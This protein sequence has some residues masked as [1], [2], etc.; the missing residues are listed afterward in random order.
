MAMV[1]PY[2]GR[3]AVL[4]TLHGKLE[5][6]AP[7]MVAATG[8]RI[9]LAELD[10]DRLGTFSGEIERQ[11]T[12]M[13]TV[14]KKARMGMEAMGMSLG[15]ASE[16]SIGPDPA[17]PF[18]GVDREWVVLVDDLHGMVVAEQAV[19]LGVP[20]V[21]GVFG[22]G[23]LDAEWLEKAGFP[24]HGLI[25][26]PEGR[27]GA[28]VFKG[29]CDRA[30]LAQ[31]MEAAAAVSPSGRV[32]VESDLR[33][34]VSPSRQRVIAEAAER[35]GA[36]LKRFCPVCGSPGWGVVSLLTGLPCAAC[37]VWIPQA[38]RGVMEGCCACFHQREIPE[39]RDAADPGRCPECNP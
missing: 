25:V 2:A 31:A 9:E 37:G 18:F 28:G 21:R 6:I 30:G 4:T 17:F 26:R 8:M 11:G 12:A 15:L 5:W 14:V 36:R 16:G 7:A 35:L 29:L 19:S 27:F 39:A 34:H 10:T 23:E 33:A 13:E 20:A 32:L 38:R 24:E 1:H 3:L 22:P